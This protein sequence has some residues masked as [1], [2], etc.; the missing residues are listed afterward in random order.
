MADK[1]AGPYGLK[2][3]CR[4]K[5]KKSFFQ[6][7]FLHGQLR[8]FQLVFKNFSDR[9]CFF[10]KESFL[11]ST[12]MRFFT[13]AVFKPSLGLCQLLKNRLDGCWIDSIV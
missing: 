2:F 7:I 5:K 1:N 12:F 3:F 10:Y 9:C 13:L 6:H 11:M 8:A 4:Q